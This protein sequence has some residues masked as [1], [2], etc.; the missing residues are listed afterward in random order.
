MCL[1][2]VSVLVVFTEPLKLPGSVCRHSTHVTHLL[3]CI[4]IFYLC[5]LFVGY[6]SSL[7][8]LF[9]CPSD[10][11]YLLFMYLNSAVSI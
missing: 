8:V 4:Y 9:I 11:K 1:Q 2:T 10:N 6:V 3:I 7:F 5:V